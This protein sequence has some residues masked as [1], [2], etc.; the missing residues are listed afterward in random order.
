MFGEAREEPIKVV[1]GELPGERLGG[2]LVT[3]LEGHKAL[4]QGFEVCEVIGSEHLALEDR[5]VDLDLAL[6]Q[7]A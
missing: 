2:H 6:S 7:E 1:A 5:E 4:G 3:L